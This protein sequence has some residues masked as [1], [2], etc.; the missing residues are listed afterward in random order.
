MHD[1]IPND[2]TF[3]IDFCHALHQ[4]KIMLHLIP[5]PGMAYRQEVKVPG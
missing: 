5:F 3:E 1:L 2:R 4:I